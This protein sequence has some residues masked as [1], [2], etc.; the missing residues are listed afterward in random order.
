MTTG[1]PDEVLCVR[2]IYKNGS[3]GAVLHQRRSDVQDWADTGPHTYEVLTVTEVI[4]PQKPKWPTLDEAIAEVTQQRFQH[5]GFQDAINVLVRVAEAAKAYVEE[6]YETHS[7][8]YSEAAVAKKL[9]A[10]RSAVRGED[11]P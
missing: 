2:T 3:R 5:C 7:L 10:L 6:R 11:T 8:Q 9:N 1:K 4:A